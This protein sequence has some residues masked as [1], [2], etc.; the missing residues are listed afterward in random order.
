MLR[1]HVALFFS[2]NNG[3]EPAYIYLTALST[4]LFGRTVFAVR[5]AAALTGTLTT[6]ITYKLAAAW[7]SQR[8][9]LLAAWLWAI[10][11]WP[12]HLSR[13]GLRPILLVPLLA[14]TLW[15]GTLAYR[16]RRRRWWIIAGLL[17]GLSFYTYLPVRFTPL[18]FLLLLLYL[19]LRQRGKDWRQALWPG[20]G[21]FT[22]TTALVTA[23]LVWLALQNPALVLGRI[24]QV[25]ILDPAING[26]DLWG[27]LW[28]H[29][30]QGLGM[31]CWRGDVILRHNPAGRPVF[32]W[33]MSV[34]FLGGVA[35]CARH[36]R[37]PTA[38]ALLLWS[39]VMLGPTI[40]AEDTPHFL[41]AVGVL[42]A[43]LFFPALGLNQ[44]AAWPR[45]RYTLI[46][47]LLLGSLALTIRDYAAYTRQP[48]TAYLFESGARDLAEQINADHHSQVIYLEKRFADN[49]PSIRFLVNPE[50]P[51]VAFDATI[52]PPPIIAG[53]A[54]LY[55]WPYQSLDFLR[56]TLPPPA[57]ISAETGSLGRGDLEPEPYPLFVHFQR[58]PI[59][60]RAALTRFGDN[61]H[62]EQV[63]VAQTDPLHLAVT[64]TW[65]TDAPITETLVAFVHVSDDGFL[66][67]QDDQQ[68]AQG[69]WPT[70]WWQP[71]LLVRDQHLI[72]LDEAYDPARHPVIVGLY[73]ADTLIRLP[74]FTPNGAPIGDTWQIK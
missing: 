14:A 51:V 31:C 56:Q 33:L 74:V 45:L 28:R 32:D 26:G 3:R 55:I 39:G 68:P 60:P 19:M 23:P 1:G 64:L 58:E 4:A 72:T 35:W 9:G 11:L 2:A 41:R 42:P 10:T 30:W 59:P 73:S 7:F 36:W 50:Q 37:R 65:S 47:L 34:P 61:I 43:F 22:I 71:D 46:P 5:L 25:S 66:I 49:W 20:L 16:Q 40:L 53:S 15:I 54:G 12:I 18:L 52:P 38:A 21:W 69:Y 67:G 70:T 44:L 57:L 27:T 8:V 63:E 48:D 6:W 62:L 29:T 17:Y 24:G 13:I